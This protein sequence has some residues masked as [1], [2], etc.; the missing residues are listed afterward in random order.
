M[1]TEGD[2]YFNPGKINDLLVV[3]ASYGQQMVSLQ[4]TAVGDQLDM[5]QGQGVLLKKYLTM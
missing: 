1:F 4:W 5:G 2:K 3:S